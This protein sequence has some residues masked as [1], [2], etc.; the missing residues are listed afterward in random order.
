MDRIKKDIEYDYFENSSLLSIIKEKLKEGGILNLIKETFEYIG[1]IFIGEFL[2]LKPIRYFE[3][4]GKKLP[5]FYHKYNKT[6]KNERAV[7]IPIML[8]RYLREFYGDKRILEVGN[9][10]QHYTNL[11]SNNADNRI[12]VVRLGN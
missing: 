9:V 11:T 2:N 6:W 4:N 12:Y 10:L 8:K 1:D 5:Y 7:E 3:Y